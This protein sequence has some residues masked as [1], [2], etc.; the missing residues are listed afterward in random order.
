[1]GMGGQVHGGGRGLPSWWVWVCWDRALM[2]LHSTYHTTPH[3]SVPMAKYIY[4]M[5]LETGSEPSPID[6][7]KK[8]HTKKDGKE[9]ATDKAKTL[10]DGSRDEEDNSNNDKEVENSL[11]GDSQ[12]D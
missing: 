6:C 12:E 11:E 1:M 9:W 8:F 2:G 3:G 4:E 5:Y 7:F 10:H